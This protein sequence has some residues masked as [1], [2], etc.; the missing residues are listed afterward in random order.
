MPICVALLLGLST[1][2]FLKQSLYQGLALRVAVWI[3]SDH[4]SPFEHRVAGREFWLSWRQAQIP[5]K[6][7]SQHVAHD[8]R[9]RLDTA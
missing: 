8:D 9:P 7:L 4:Q 3:Q 2:R 1:S 5:R 6:R